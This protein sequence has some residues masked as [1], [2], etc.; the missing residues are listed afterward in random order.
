MSDRTQAAI[1]SELLALAWPI[2]GLNV[3]QVLALA[4]DT[5]MVGH[6][7]DHAV[8]LTGMGYAG[9]IAF[10]LMVGMIG[11]TVGTVAF[12]SRAHGTGDTERTAHILQQSIQLTVLLG[13]V[14]A[15]VGNLLAPTLLGLLNAQGPE[16]EAG[17]AYLRPL[18]L[19][20]VFNYLNIL[21][22]AAL[23]GVGNTRLAFAVA[24]VMN[25]LNAVLNYGLIFGNFGLPA[26]GVQGAAVGTVIAQAVAAI[27][28]FALLHRR[29]IP[30]LH[31][32]LGLE[33]IDRP[34]VGDIVRVGWPAGL[35]MVVFNVGFLSIVG[36][37]GTLDQLAVGAHTVGLR[38]QALAFVPGMSIAQ[39][40]GALVGVSLGAGDV[41]DARRVLRA[42]T[43]LS[44]AVMSSLGLVLIGFAGPIVQLF[45]LSPHEPM[46]AYS[47]QWMTLLGAGM[48]VVGIY[49]SIAAL[50]DGAGATRMS[51]RI[52]A[53]VTAVQIPLSWLLGFPLGL[54]PWGVW[55]AFPASFVLKLAWAWWIY[56]QDGWAQTGSH[57]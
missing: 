5:A 42:S 48:P 54:G 35:N 6:S 23:R 39:A 2:I 20:T 27:L 3:L 44:A 33:P 29:L 34:L 43:V 52:N 7:P 56:R 15:V 21:F 9:Q 19:G 17:L 26:L 47:V 4:V 25:G 30:G 53:V 16:L 41:L 18:L 31:P 12:V 24:L 57:I 36:M 14:V 51:L 8:A 49:M 1:T 22:A 10:L 32:E 45:D 28:M 40:T 13:G 38:I 37:L 55:L 11:L 46:F 50:L